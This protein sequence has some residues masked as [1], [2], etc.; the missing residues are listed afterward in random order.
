MKLKSDF[1]AHDTGSE[2][3][4]VGTGN[5]GFSGIVRGNA[6][7]GAILEILADDVT[8]EQI[9]AEMKERFDAPEGAIERDVARA[10]AELTRI[11]AID[12]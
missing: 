12:G 10:L 1:V 11:G 2:T 6:T 3:V 7:F 4:L 5:S 9:V 8:E